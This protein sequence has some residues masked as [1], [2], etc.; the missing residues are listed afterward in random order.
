MRLLRMSDAPAAID[1]ARVRLTWDPGHRMVHMSFSGPP[2]SEVS[3]A[4]A[5]ACIRALDEWTAGKSILFLV[6]CGQLGDADAGWRALFADYFRRRRNELRVAWFNMSP[7]IR[8]M[9]QMFVLGSGVRGRGFR[10]E[11]EARAWLGLPSGG[12]SG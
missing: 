10:S 7:F 11:A 8:L 4:D 3:E 9:V 2:R 12:A 5:R 1:I 6:D